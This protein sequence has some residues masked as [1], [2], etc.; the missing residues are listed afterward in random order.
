[1]MDK[2][3]R[4]SRDGVDIDIAD[5]SPEAAEDIANITLALRTAD[6]ACITA[7]EV[8]DDIDIAGAIERTV[9]V[10]DFCS[11]AV[12]ADYEPGTA[13]A[14]IRHP[15][16]RVAGDAACD[17]LVR[18]WWTLI[19]GAT[20]TA[21]PTADPVAALD[22]IVARHRAG[23]YPSVAT[24]DWLVDGLARWR[25]SGGTDNLAQCLGLGES[26]Q[27]RGQAANKVTVANRKKRNGLALGTVN[28]LTTVFGLTNSEAANVVVSWLQELYPNKPLSVATIESMWDKARRYKSPEVRDLLKRRYWNEDARRLYLRDIPQHCWQHLPQLRRYL[29]AA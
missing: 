18:E 12:S 4:T 27:A 9:Y 5:I 14:L 19:G 17:L 20:E 24:L 8:D 16:P 1:M 10:E 28:V 29:P 23:V 2:E 25:E 3:W 15:P 21:D 11:R 6:T 22:S 26:S 7:G 13:P